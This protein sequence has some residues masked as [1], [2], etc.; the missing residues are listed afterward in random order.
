MER[1]LVVD[2]DTRIRQLLASFLTQKGFEVQTAS[3]PLDARGI[4]EKSSFDVL[5]V[6][7]MM[8]HEDGLSFV[9]HLRKTLNVPVLFLTAKDTLEDKVQG[10]QGGGDD[11]LVKPFEPEELSLRIR[12]L[13]R[14]SGKKGGVFIRLGMFSFN[15]Q[16]GRL[17]D[18]QQNLI[19][20]TSTEQ[21]L[22]KNLADS[23]GEPLSREFLSNSLGYTVCDR[24]IDVQINRLRKKIE[25]DPK[26][27]IYL[28]TIRH[29][30]YG[31][32]LR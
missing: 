3:D 12:A 23:L 15:A 20:L 4:L 28:R 19:F 32:F 24:T 17:Y 9:R 11:Y 7:I 14:R 16:T 2:D 30:G 27:P 22:L 18:E 8:P 6:D 31:L 29:K 13:I 21:L 25:E 10:F 26:N 1:I 5:V